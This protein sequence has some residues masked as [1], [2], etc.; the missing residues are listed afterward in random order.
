MTTDAVYY[1]HAGR[2]SLARRLSLK[3]RLS[4]YQKFIAK[5]KP[6]KYDSILDVGTSGV[7][8][9]KANILQKNYPY[10]SKI[11]CA[12]LSDVTSVI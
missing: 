10:L 9:E 7:D 11:T 2:L 8:S 3:S 12:S 6:A 5:T 1:Q 4:I